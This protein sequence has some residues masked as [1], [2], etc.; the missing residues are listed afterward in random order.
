MPLIM[1]F[2]ILGTHFIAD[3]TLQT[4]EMAKNKSKSNQWLLRHV[5]IYT[6]CFVWTL[7]PI[8]LLYTGVMHFLTDYVTSRWSSK[9]WKE[10][11]VHDFFVVIGL[12]QFIH[13]VTL[14][15]A[16]YYFVL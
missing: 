13:Q 11:K 5:C 1:L 9:L 15:W 4:D 16:F 3:F 10:E 12:D 7:S 8:F 2:L 6:L 14:I